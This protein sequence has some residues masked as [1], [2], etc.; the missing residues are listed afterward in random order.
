[1]IL[2]TKQKQEIDR[3]GKLIANLVNQSGLLS[4]PVM[5]EIIDNPAGQFIIANFYLNEE[6][7][8]R[9]QYYIEPDGLYKGFLV[10]N[11]SGVNSNMGK[12]TGMLM[13]HLQLLLVM[14]SGARIFN[15]NNYTDEPARAAQGI[16]SLLSVNTTLG[17]HG[18]PRSEFAGK[19]LDDKLQLSE[20]EMRLVVDA[21]SMT[22][23]NTQM[24]QLAS[25]VEGRGYPWNPNV[26]KNMNKF[27]GFIP[28]YGMYGGRKAK[29]KKKTLKKKHRKFYKKN[30]KKSR[31][32]RKKSRKL[33][34]KTKMQK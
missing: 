18:T 3:K 4:V 9:G 13:F 2:G 21:G 23:W 25:Q 33:K 1:M 7:Y 26:E 29:K 34:A 28:Q 15:L 5:F 22:K 6:T 16:Y 32:K 30:T 20:G 11:G 19:S 8:S 12:R 24:L 10:A 31:K 27:L 14:T 17:T